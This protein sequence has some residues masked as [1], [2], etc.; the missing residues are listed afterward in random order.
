MVE[1]LLDAQQEAES[2]TPNPVIASVATLSPFL[3]PQLEAGNIMSAIIPRTYDEAFRMAACFV[4]AG[5]VGDALKEKLGSEQEKK[6]GTLAKVATAIMKGLEIGIPPVG[7]M[8]TITIINGRPCVWGDALPA[9]INKTGKVEYI[10]EWFTGTQFQDDWTAHC[11]LKRKDQTE[12]YIKTFS[13]AD[14]KKAGLT[15]KGPWAQ[16]P[17]RMLQMRA[18]S[19]TVRDGFADAL[20]GL[21]VAEEIQDYEVIERRNK[22]TDTNSLE[23]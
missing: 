23:D 9:L 4:G 8:Q 5:I 6:N 13:L 3:K 14:A 11:E 20:M 12:P 10:K 15:G 21:G 18:R 16:Y 7:A 19:W 1:K 17:Q 2:D 22:I